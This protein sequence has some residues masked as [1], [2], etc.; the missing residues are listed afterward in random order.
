M[1]QPRQD[2]FTRDLAMSYD[3]RNSTLAAISSCLHFLA[4][5]ILKNIPARSKVLCVGAGTGAEILTLSKIYP[6]WT[7]VALEPSAAMLEVCRERLKAADLL[8]R[9]ELINGYVQDLVPEQ[10]FNAVISF[11]VG[12]FIKSEDKISFFRH[13][14]NRL[15]DGGYLINA[16][17][18]YD[19]DSAECPSM[20]THWRAVQTLMGATAESLAALPELMKSALSILPTNE[21][22]NLIRES[23]I[24]MPIRFF[25]AFMISGWYGV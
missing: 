22:K 19:L 11:L 1:A 15:Q 5:L 7:F 21:V 12:H 18:S 17:I 3:E 6:E 25:Q 10:K 2:F 8:N 24:A 4:G 13:M 9:C 14:T 20:L 23:G 16:E